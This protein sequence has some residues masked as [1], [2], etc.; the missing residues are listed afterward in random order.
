M[1]QLLKTA[2]DLV[3]AL[4]EKK[5]EADAILARVTAREAALSS[6]EAAFAD[7]LKA[8]EIQEDA[9]TLYKAA[10]AARDEANAKALQ[11]LEAEAKILSPEALAKRGA[12]LEQKQ[13]ALESTFG[14]REQE[15]QAYYNTSAASLQESF[16]TVATQVVARKGCALMFDK[17]ATYFV[18]PTITDLTEDIIKEFDQTYR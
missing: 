14:G 7:R 2:Q 4:K 5:A 18:G 12:E 6:K 16:A 13:A 10:K 8:R 17:S 11:N 15:L 3:A 9:E 1:E